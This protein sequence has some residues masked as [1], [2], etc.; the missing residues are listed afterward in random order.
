MATPLGADLILNMA[1]GG[2]SLDQRF[3]AACDVESTRSE[4]GVDVHQQRKVANVGNPAH[5]YQHVVERIDAEVWHAKR[6]GCHPA[7]RQVNR[8]I[9]HLL[10]HQRMIRNQRTDNLQRPFSL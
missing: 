5:V 7:A 9:A 8:A 4:A 1:R 6:S 3:D 10:R 2:T